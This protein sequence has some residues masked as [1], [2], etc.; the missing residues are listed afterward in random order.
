MD[1]RQST[2]F[3]IWTEFVWLNNSVSKVF[4]THTLTQGAQEEGSG[5]WSV[6][7]E[8]PAMSAS[9]QQRETLLWQSKDR[10]L[11]PA[12]ENTKNVCK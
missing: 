12:N 11:Y 10:D 1:F 6:T 4:W 2:Y 5:P 8:L 7:H 3:E 9:G